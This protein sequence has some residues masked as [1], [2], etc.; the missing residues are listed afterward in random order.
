MF[1]NWVSLYF[2]NSRFCKIVL[3]MFICKKLRYRGMLFYFKNSKFCKI[4]L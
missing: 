1:Y 2:K 4:V 3:P